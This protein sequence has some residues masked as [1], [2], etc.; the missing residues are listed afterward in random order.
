MPIIEIGVAAGDEVDIED[1]LITLE[2]D[3]ASM[4]VPS[5]HSGKIVALTVKENTWM[6]SARFKAQRHKMLG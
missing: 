4:D 2:S 5:P 6:S 1:P 3:K